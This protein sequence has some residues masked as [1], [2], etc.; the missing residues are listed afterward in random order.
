MVYRANEYWLKTMDNESTYYFS[1]EALNEN[2][3]SAMSP[4]VKAE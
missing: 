2:G 3:I 4:T 1:V